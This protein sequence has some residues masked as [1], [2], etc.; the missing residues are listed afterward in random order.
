MEHMPEVI[1]V[2]GAVL[3]NATRLHETRQ[4]ERLVG[5]LDCDALGFI[6]RGDLHAGTK[7]RRPTGASA[8]LCSTNFGR[9]RD[10]RSLTP[11]ESA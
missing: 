10:R 4:A 7:A 1:R 9:I 8:I 6:D 2:I 5:V 11:A 3:G